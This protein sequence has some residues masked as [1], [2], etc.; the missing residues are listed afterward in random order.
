MMPG[1]DPRQLAE[2]H[3]IGRNIKAVITIDYTEQKSTLEMSSDIP[4][5]AALIPN[6]LSQFAEGLAT[7]LQ[8]FFAIRGEIIEKGKK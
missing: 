4:E 6:M 2:A 8:A 5:A 1:V 7:Q 3:R